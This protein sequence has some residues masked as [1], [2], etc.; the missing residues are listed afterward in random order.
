MDLTPRR[1][2]RQSRAQSTIA[3]ILD[4]TAKL[5]HEVG[6]EGVNT[7]AIAARAGINVATLYSYFPNKYAVIVALADQIDEN[8]MSLIDGALSSADWSDRIEEVL[9]AFID[10]V[11]STPG[12][13]AL[14]DAL[15]TAP[16]LAGIDERVHQRI[17]DRIGEFLLAAPE[18]KI[19]KR[20]V[21]IVSKVL[22]EATSGVV[23]LARRASPRER[24]QI[25]RELK[26]MVTSYLT[27]RPVL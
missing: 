1:T 20:D 21:T 11:L 7:N 13:A 16:E 27:R 17:A 10:S 19:P 6:L 9:D 4:A 15:R 8:R 24:R 22:V 23:G 12:T 18:L 25:V 5:L 3:R 14:F 26:R 2:P